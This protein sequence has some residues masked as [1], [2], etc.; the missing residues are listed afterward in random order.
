VT[1][2]RA[3]HLVPLGI[4]GWEL[5]RD[6]IV[7]SAGFPARQVLELSDPALASAADNMLSG[8][9]SHTHYDAAFDAAVERL[10]AATRGIA[11]DPR[12]REAV[13]WQN[14]AAVRNCLDKV[15]AGEPRN[16]GGR[17]HEQVI[18]RYLQRYTVKNDTIG[19]FGPVGWGAW[20]EDAKTVSLNVDD[21]RRLS[22]RTVYFESWAID[23]V[24]RMLATDPAV[25]PWLSPHAVP[26]NLLVE[27]TLH[28]PKTDPAQLRDAEALLLSRCD[29]S[30]TVR[31]LAAEMAQ[32][33]Q[34]K[35]RTEED[36]AACLQRWRREGL[37]TLGFEG[38]VEAWPEKTL[39]MKLS[40]I[41]DKTVRDRV[42]EVLDRLVAAREM[43]TDAAGDDRR[44]AHA[45]DRLTEVF[46]EATGEA[47]ARRHGQMYA[48]RTLVYEDTVLDGKVG[49]G[50][51][52]RDE[53]ASPLGLVLDSARWLV[54]RIADEYR[55]LFIG[56][57]RRWSAR[58]GGPAM[59]LSTLLG[60][61]TPHL[62]YSAHNLAGPVRVAVNEFQERWVKVLDGVPDAHRSI[63][64]SDQLT[65]RIRQE[66]PATWLPWATAVHH[67]PDLMI[68]APSAEAVCQGDYLAVLG[69]LHM[70][71]N[72]FEARLF[73]EQ[74]E[75]PE[76]LLT[77]DV[78]D[79]GDGRI[80]LLPPKD[81][82][83]VTSRLTPPSALLSP[84]Y[85]YWSIRSESAIAPGP[86]VALA[87]LSVYEET[88]QLLVHSRNSGFQ[89][90]LLEFLGELLSGAAVNAFKPMAPAPHR[91][92]ITIDKMVLARE[93]W[94]FPATELSWASIRSEKER[95]LAVRRWRTEHGIPERAFYRS[96]VEVKPVF[97]E[98]S[99]ITLV[100][101]LAKVIRN[102]TAIP[103]G[104]VSLTEML[105]DIEDTWFQDRRGVA[106]TAELRI[107][108]VDPL[109]QTTESHHVH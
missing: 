12:F 106:S 2:Q 95:F 50:R 27:R 40:R 59:P 26:E 1:R 16:V 86:R 60:M 45:L 74:H 85:K 65:E 68:A 54:A 76:G 90:N 80:Y 34:P 41:G 69:E 13:T 4:S 72:P 39:R 101:M 98:F 94:T 100:N 73:V 25:V 89:A 55:D 38:P 24:A 5:W 82:S 46:E 107:V 58:H 102:T 64:T 11:S 67:A 18:A 3:G 6:V 78:A 7:R 31:E 84:R 36:V 77:A 48:G 97:V 33:D 51:S 53:L 43:V 23:T 52:L 19:F 66:F 30:R 8:S 103:D 70:A 10:T 32:T 9:A 57:H 44:L 37:V 79:H 21:A 22:R 109:H 62:F 15:A 81:W 93:S 47:A 105:P 87:D 108:A 88:G 104:V 42:M 61:A 63:F 92:R 20:T 28:R 96:P 49:L 14:R 75:D 35:L 56:M 99:S 91:P 71:F 83:T 29:G 17:K